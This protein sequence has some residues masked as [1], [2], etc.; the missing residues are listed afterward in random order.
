[1][2]YTAASVLDIVGIV[3]V[4]VEQEGCSFSFFFHCKAQ[5]ASPSGTNHG[6][7]QSAAWQ[8]PWEL[9]SDEC[10]TMIEF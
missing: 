9:S 5:C 8:H 10:M 1:M 3:V 7:T 6:K 4:V 2:L